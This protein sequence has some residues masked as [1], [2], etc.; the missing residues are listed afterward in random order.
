M[1]ESDLKM[2]KD[3]LCAE[4]IELSDIKGGGVECRIVWV[5]DGETFEEVSQ[6]HLMFADILPEDEFLAVNACIEQLR[7]KHPDVLEKKLTDSSVKLSQLITDEVNTAIAKLKQKC[8]T[9]DDFKYARK[10]AGLTREELANM[11]NMSENTV[12]F[13]ERF[14]MPPVSMRQIILYKLWDMLHK[15]VVTELKEKLE[16]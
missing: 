3:E 7:Q 1:I 9:G 11:L 12:V 10:A 6:I 16:Q 5:D 13:F 15:G 4:S 14:G 2:L 8:V